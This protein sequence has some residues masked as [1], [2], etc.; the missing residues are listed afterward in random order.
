MNSKREKSLHRSKV[1]KLG[2]INASNKAQLRR[3]NQLKKLDNRPQVPLSDFYMLV[4]G[5]WTHKGRACRLC[6]SILNDPIVLD[7]HRYICKVLNKVE[8]DE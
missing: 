2:G 1:S 3:I 6:G 4:N 7:K 8:E 5:E